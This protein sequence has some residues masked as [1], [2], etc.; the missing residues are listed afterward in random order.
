MQDVVYSH[1]GFGYTRSRLQK[2]AKDQQISTSEELSL[3]VIRR[4]VTRADS[5]Q[6]IITL[7]K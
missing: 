6:F 7:S 4:R 3:L 2:M 1:G 5:S